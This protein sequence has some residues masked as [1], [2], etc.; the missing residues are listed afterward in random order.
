V[1][2]E[3]EDTCVIVSKKE[4]IQNGDK[5]DLRCEML[6][7]GQ[8]PNTKGSSFAQLYSLVAI[9]DLGSHMMRHERPH[10][11][12]AGF[13]FLAGHDCCCGVDDDVGDGK[14]GSFLARTGSRLLSGFDSGST[15]SG[16]AV[17][18]R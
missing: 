12:T 10:Q 18:R 5:K 8:Y 9:G 15:F 3:K 16:V 4:K 17:Q 14:N 13:F 1:Q 2:Y 11:W 6:D 7:H